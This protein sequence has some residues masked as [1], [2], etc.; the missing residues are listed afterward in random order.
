MRCSVSLF[1]SSLTRVP[2]C[3]CPYLYVQSVRVSRLSITRT[4]DILLET[5]WTKC[6]KI[7][8]KLSIGQLSDILLKLAWSD[9]PRIVHWINQNERSMYAIP[10]SSAESEKECIRSWAHII[11]IK[12]RNQAQHSGKT[13]L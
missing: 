4:L 7:V 6:P 2:N 8:R 3:P 1:I 5:T 9:C 11:K 10:A 13:F 12:K